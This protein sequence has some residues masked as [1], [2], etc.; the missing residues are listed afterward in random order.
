MAQH[1]AVVRLKPGREQSLRQKQG[2][3]RSPDA[4]L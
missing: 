2:R 4:A 1:A 3:N